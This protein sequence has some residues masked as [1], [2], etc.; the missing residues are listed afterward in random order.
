M[1]AY[2]T[3]VLAD[4]AS[5][6]WTMEGAGP[7]FVD[8]VGGLVATNVGGATYN[9]VANGLDGAGCVKLNGS[10][11]YF[12]VP[13]NAA[14]DL[15]DVFT[16]ELWLKK[17]NIASAV[18]TFLEK[19]VDYKIVGNSSDGLTL[20]KGE[21]A[22]NNI[23]TQRIKQVQRF[24]HV[25]M[26]KD[27]TPLG[28][29]IFIDGVDRSGPLTSA[30]FGNNATQLTIGVRTNLTAEFANASFQK[31][32]LYKTVLTPTQIQAHYA[33]IAQARNSVNSAQTALNSITL[34]F[35]VPAGNNRF[36]VATIAIRQSASETVQSVTWN[37]YLGSPQSLTLVDRISF[38]AASVGS[39]MW[40]LL[41]PTV[42]AGTV[43]AVLASGATAAWVLGASEFSGVDQTTPISAYSVTTGN[44]AT[45]AGTVASAVGET[46]ID[47]MAMQD[48]STT[49]ANNFGVGNTPQYSD[50]SYLAG[51]TGSANCW[52]D[53]GTKAGA[54]S[55]TMNYTRGGNALPWATIVA[56][57]KPAP[58]GSAV[59]QTATVVYEAILPRTVTAGVVYEGLLPLAQQAFLTYEAI[60]LVTAT[61][62]GVYEALSPRTQTATLAYEALLSTTRQ[63]GV[64]YEALKAVSQS[65][66]AVYE[67]LRLATKTGVVNY[68]ALLRATATGGIP[69][70]G[71][72]PT[73]ATS[74]VS[75]AIALVYEALKPLSVTGVVVYEGVKA[76]TQ[77]RVAN[78]E[79]IKPVTQSRQAVYEALGLVSATRILPYEALQG[80]RGLAGTSYEA[81]GAKTKQALLLYEAIRLVTKQGT[82]PYEGGDPTATS[83]TTFKQTP[84]D[85]IEHDHSLFRGCQLFLDVMLSTS[86]S[87]F[88]AQARL[89]VSTDGGSVWSP[90]I[91]ASTTA[92][93]IAIDPPTNSV[94]IGTRVRSAA[95]P[96]GLIPAGSALYRVTLGGVTN[97]G[98]NIY[99]IY[100]GWGL[101]TE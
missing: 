8:L 7:N 18:R 44:T 40:K 88:A 77:S 42:G 78:Y 19:G 50:Q 52:G 21:T 97:A 72:I 33:L 22:A 58:A 45:P 32:A 67:A 91:V 49:F 20:N 2:D 71:G 34:G 100:H 94:F 43:V 89:E 39:E 12:T 93:P 9:D 83:T 82:I 15:G 63:A 31:L 25:V 23:S 92:L 69:Y 29:K 61:A 68:E 6:Y 11:Q 66:A 14:L 81:L 36:M 56:S 1:T 35:N 53:S 54:A 96:P 24:H 85:I 60:G 13:S 4:G 46:T 64:S 10:T 80:I 41:Q 5:A 76:I 51:S 62:Q 30:T 74:P 28:S 55:V 86:N 16:L 27:G 98:S 47:S 95:V 87:L 65:R 79:A 70:E 26:T 37:P 38:G 99:R 57:I 101:V 90:L 48:T 84:L 59:S 73:A 3:Q 75:R 17:S